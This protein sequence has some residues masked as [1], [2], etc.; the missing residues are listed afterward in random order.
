[1]SAGADNTLRV[2]VADD[3]GMLREIAAAM[4]ENAG[5]AVETV[6]GGDAAVAACL[7]RM[8]DLILLDVEMPEGNGY[9]ACTN[10]RALPSGRDVPIVMVTGFDDAA[11][12]NLAYDA[13]AT[14]FVVKPINWAL[15]VHRLRYVLRGARTIEALRLSEQKNSA[16]LRAIPDGIFLVSGSGAVSHCFS[17]LPALTEPQGRAATAPHLNELLPPQVLP[18]ALE[19]LAATLRGAPASFE[20]SLAEQ[21]AAS[22]HFEC[23]Y[24]PNATGQVLAIVRDIS[25]RKQTEAHIHRL[26]YFDA[27]TGLPNREWIGDYLSQSLGAVAGREQ[28]L[29]LLFIDLDQFKR[30]NDTLG[31]ETGDAL[32][33][34]VAGRLSAALGA[35]QAQL[36]RVGGDE[37]IVVLTAAGASAAEQAAQRIQSALAAP[38][39]HGGYEFVV[40]SSIGIALYPEHGAD[41]QTLLKNADGAM[42]E[43]K[44]SGRNQFR[45][46]TSAVHARAVKRLSLEMELRRAFESSQL[47]VYYQPQYDARTLRMAGAEALL[48]WFHPQRGRIATA[49]FVAVAEE[50]GL[51]GDIGRWTLQQVCRDLQRWRSAGRAV[52]SIA[53]NVSGR[54]FMRQDVLLRLSHVVEEARLPASLFE[55]ELTEGVLMQDVEGGQRS[56]LALKEFGFALAVDDFGTGYCSLNYLKRFP[57]DT[58]KVDRTFVND[59][60]VDADNAAIVRAIIGLGHNLDLKLVAEGVET[61]AQLEFL[62]AAGCDLIQGFLMS[63]AVP[64]DSLLRLLDTTAPLAPRQDVRQGVEP[65]VPGLAAAAPRSA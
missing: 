49:D 59:I 33:K 43:A 23:R 8:P 3:D 55:L 62:R 1:M 17:P 53:V 50:T 13:G 24:L 48:R 37:F 40:T 41:A 42:Y 5:F 12:I 57:L 51:I 2:L 14:D 29:A 32:L 16:L 26:A 22:Q 56:L 36:A 44:A 39:V 11:S 65:A 21:P 46:Y 52:P 6:A 19:A 35:G 34:Q 54:D 31:H 58:L 20:F 30:I 18:R 25:Q 9:Q 28:G 7:A 61:Q 4:L 60:T 38:F 64:A 63:E 15:L 27:L 47:E 10:I 45:V